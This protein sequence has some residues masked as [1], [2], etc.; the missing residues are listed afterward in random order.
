MKLCLLKIRKLNFIII[1]TN[2][3]IPNSIYETNML[4]TKFLKTNILESEQKYINY[5]NKLT[6]LIRNAEQ[7]NTPIVLKL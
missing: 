5:K 1:D 3:D 4:Y 2:H 7:K 6:S